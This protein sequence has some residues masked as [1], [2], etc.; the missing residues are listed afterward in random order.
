[1]TEKPLKI[2]RRR[3]KIHGNGVFATAPIRKGEHIVEYKGRLITHDQADE[4]Y[5]GDVASGHTFLFTLN[6]QW[7]LD[8]NVKGNVARWINTSCEPN[9]I[10]FVHE[11]KKKNPD[12]KNDR[13]IIEA[14]RTIQPGEEIFYDYGFEFDLPYTKELLKTWAC[15]CGSK[16]CRGTML[17]GKKYKAFVKANP[18]WNK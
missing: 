15:R 18:D 12:P 3:S 13:V 7:I 6:D 8:A 4:Q 11:E 16:K 10:A 5:H 17:S 1:M 2:V 9:A 14:L